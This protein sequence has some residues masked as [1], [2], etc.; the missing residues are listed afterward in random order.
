MIYWGLLLVGYVLGS[1]SPAYF[2][3]RVLKN[4]DIR[5]IG[6]KNAGT[7][8]VY[9]ELGLWPAVITAVYDFFKGLLA[10]YFAYLLGAPTIVIYSCGLAAIIGH[11][12]PFYLGFRGG[13]GSATSVGLLFYYLFELIKNGTLTLQSLAILVPV[14]LA[15]FIITHTKEFLGLVALPIV[16]VMILK[17][18]PINLE[19]IFA[20][21]SMTQLFIASSYES[22][23][24]KLFVLKPSTRKEMLVWRS[25]LR[26]LAIIFPL[27]Y[28]YLDRS[29]MLW[30]IGVIAA[31]PLTADLLRLLVPRINFF[32]FKKATAIFKKREKRYFSSITFFLW[33]IFILILLFP[34]PIAILAASFLIFG[35]LFSKFF[36]MEY[37]Q[38]KIFQHKTI[39]GSIAYLTICLVLGYILWPYLSLSPLIIVSGAIFATLAELFS[40]GINDNLSVA[41]ASGISMLILDKFV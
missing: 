40:K 31:I 32:F 23:R 10:M 18:A 24:K 20:V 33:S 15:I 35:D 13:Q 39:E 22:Y 21:V 7:T 19:A 17:H 9:H 41:L 14:I 11:I 25:L 1:I 30:V 26:P 3:G 37:G 29:F 16:S 28:F 2:L 36:G 5:T 34:K 6:S 12:F 8:N 27:A 4:V 38:I